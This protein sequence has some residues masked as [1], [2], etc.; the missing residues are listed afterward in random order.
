MKK[1]FLKKI[2]KFVCVLTI[3]SLFLQFVPAR[4]PAQAS[5]VGDW[6]KKLTTKIALPDITVT[7][8]GALKVGSYPLINNLP[9]NCAQ[10]DGNGNCIKQVNPFSQ[11]TLSIDGKQVQSQIDLEEPDLVPGCLDKYIEASCDEKKSFDEKVVCIADTTSMLKGMPSEIPPDCINSKKG[12][13]TIPKTSLPEICELSIP[14]PGD[15]NCSGSGEKCE[16]KILAKNK[17]CIYLNRLQTSAA[18]E[19]YS[20]FKIFNATDPF[21]D[22]SFIRNCRTNCSL[23]I[24]E[25]AFSVS[26][27]DVAALFIPGG[28]LTVIQKILNI[29]KM[30][31]QAF[32]IYTAIKD[33]LSSGVTFLNDLF[34]VMGQ[35]SSMYASFTNL[36]L[37]WSDVL[38][39]GG[40]AVASI[41]GGNQLK[42]IG[43]SSGG[44]IGWLEG[45]AGSALTAGN[46]LLGGVAASAVLNTSRVEKAVNGMQDMLGNFAQ[47]NLKF[48]TAKSSAIQANEKLKSSV[49][50]IRT[51]FKNEDEFSFFFQIEAQ[52]DKK[53][54]LTSILND[55]Q[56][57]F[58][59]VDEFMSDISQTANLKDGSNLSDL[60]KGDWS[61]FCDPSNKDCP[62]EN[63]PYY[64]TTTLPTR[65]IELDFSG[66]VNTG[67]ESSPSFLCYLRNGVKIGESAKCTGTWLDNF[68]TATDGSQTWKDAFELLNPEYIA[69][70][71]VGCENPCLDES[72]PPTAA[73]KGQCDLICYKS[74]GKCDISYQNKNW[75]LYW[76]DL[77]RRVGTY[78][79]FLLARQYLISHGK[80][81]IA[82]TKILDLLLGGKGKCVN[83]CSNPN[84]VPDYR[85]LYEYEFPGGVDRKGTTVEGR[86]SDFLH[87]MV[88]LFPSLSYIRELDALY[89]ESTSW[90]GSEDSP[91]VRQKIEES[92]QSLRIGIQ[93][94]IGFFSLGLN[95]IKN[96][97]ENLNTCVD[98]L[99]TAPNPLEGAQYWENI[100][101]YSNTPTPINSSAWSQGYNADVAYENWDEKINIL[102]SNAEKIDDVKQALELGVS[103]EQPIV[104]YKIAQ[105]NDILEKIKATAQ[106][107]NDDNKEQWQALVDQ[108][109]N[110]IIYGNPKDGFNG[111]CSV[112]S[113]PIDNTQDIT[114]CLRDDRGNCRN[115]YAKE[116]N[117]VLRDRCEGG[118]FQTKIFGDNET[119]CKNYLNCCADQGNSPGANACCDIG[120]A[121][122][123]GLQTNKDLYFG[124]PDTGS[125]SYKEECD[126]C[127]N[128]SCE[129]CSSNLPGGAVCGNN[130][131]ETGEQCDDGNTESQDGCSFDCQYEKYKCN[132]A[133]CS[134]VGN[135]NGIYTDSKCE[136]KCVSAPPDSGNYKCRDI[137]NQLGTGANYW[138]KCVEYPTQES[139]FVCA[140]RMLSDVP[141]RK[142]C[143]STEQNCINNVGTPDITP[144]KYKCSGSPDYVCSENSSG[145]YTSLATCRNSCQKPNPNLG[146]TLCRY[147]FD[148]SPLAPWCNCQESPR[149]T[150]A[151]CA[152]LRGCYPL[153]STCND[154]ELAGTTPPPP[155][156]NTKHYRC[157]GANCLR[158]DE[159]GAYTTSNC[160][161]RCNATSPTYSCRLVDVNGPKP[162]CMCQTGPTYESNM[163]CINR[164]DCYVDSHC[165]VSGKSASPFAKNILNNLQQRLESFAKSLIAIPKVF[166]QTA[167]QYCYSGCVINTCPNTLS[168]CNASFD[169]FCRT[170]NRYCALEQNIYDKYKCFEHYEPIYSNG[171]V[172][173]NEGKTQIENLEAQRGS[174]KNAIITIDENLQSVIK[175]ISDSFQGLQSD[176][177]APMEW[178]SSEHQESA[179]ASTTINKI[180]KLKI[181]SQDII[182]KQIP[183]AQSA[184]ATINDNIT[185][186]NQLIVAVGDNDQTRTLKNIVD[187]FNRAI[188]ILKN[189]SI[190]MNGDGVVNLDD[191]GVIDF[192][193]AKIGPQGLG[194][195][196]R[197][198]VG[199]CSGSPGN[200]TFLCKLACFEESNGRTFDQLTVYPDILFDIENAAFG[201][202]QAGENIKAIEPSMDMNPVTIKPNL[203][204]EVDEKVQCCRAGCPQ[205]NNNSCSFYRSPLDKD[206]NAT[207]DKDGKVITETISCSSWTLAS[208]KCDQKTSLYVGQ[209][210][211]TSNYEYFKTN[212]LANP[213][214]TL[215]E[216]FNAVSASVNNY[217]MLAMQHAFTDI[218]KTDT[219]PKID[220]LIK[221]NKVDVDEKKYT[222]L[223]SNVL[224]QARYLWWDLI[225]GNDTVSQKLL[226][227]CNITEQIL[228][229]N[230]ADI[231][232]QC[233][234]RLTQKEGDVFVNLS[235]LPPKALP[236]NAQGTGNTEEGYNT[237]K[238]QCNILTS[239]DLDVLE[240]LKDNSKYI[241]D[242]ID[243]LN[244]LRGDVGPDHIKC[245]KWFCLNPDSGTRGAGM[246]KVDPFCVKVTNKYCQSALDASEGVILCDK[247]SNAPNSYED[248][249]RDIT[250]NIVWDPIANPTDGSKQWPPVGANNWQGAQDMCISTQQEIANLNAL[251]EVL[252]S[253]G[254]IDD[255]GAVIYDNLDGLAKQC[256]NL[257]YQIDFARDCY[258]FSILQKAFGG[259]V[260]IDENWKDWNLN[261]F[262]TKP[263]VWKDGKLQPGTGEITSQ[264]ED[265]ANVKK[266]V[267][268]FCQSND[269]TQGKIITATIDPKNSNKS[270]GDFFGC[271]SIPLIFG[272]DLGVDLTANTADAQQAREVALKLCS[273][274]TTDMR[275]PLNE[276]MK[277][278]SVL[279]GVKSYTAASNGLSALYFDAQKVRQRAEDVVNLIKEAPKKFAELWN[280]TDEIQKITKD[281]VKI[282]Y[283][284]CIASPM[285][286]YAG[287]SQPLTGENGGPVC[288]NVN[289][290]FNQLDASFAMV[291]QN[292][293]AIDMTRRQPTKAIGLGKLS[294]EIPGEDIYPMDPDLNDIVGP[295][296]EKA[297]DIKNK[298]QLLWALATA[299]N[300]ANENCSCGQSYC[301][302]LGPVPLCISGL[303]LTLA[304]LK[305][306]FCHLVWTLRYPLGSLAEKLK[307]E[308]EQQ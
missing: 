269:A 2:N 216:R 221:D 208:K 91:G 49:E 44:N 300:Y 295:I 175:D 30:I 245:P 162:Y 160:D 86:H 137:S 201:L 301:P 140:N 276:I 60:Q 189:N 10:K 266:A 121:C 260:A 258:N 108:I 115:C 6:L 179:T 150:D 181:N 5:L 306:P 139:S 251:K 34:N 267:S 95:Q 308:L 152:F 191:Y 151:Q 17:A 167:K 131:T 199:K 218:P 198:G 194:N 288:P 7:E 274:S 114:T 112:E 138:C 81:A 214:S 1:N 283:V 248:G 8:K 98:N 27:L 56:L 227:A 305:E 242:R 146:S 88:D 200:S 278:L 172:E 89:S 18:Q 157:S 58:R 36:G 193:Y 249:Q 231:Q 235:L 62:I 53:K 209:Q 282:Q 48:A 156:S 190:D 307:Q 130:K 116:N 123:K 76:E 176:W 19:V 35:L 119:S 182:G 265:I 68:I 184:I 148:I 210:T 240:N 106:T 92:L 37:K 279:L 185:A 104:V 102:K 154:N 205:E 32:K 188:N 82:V 217:L 285:I 142:D 99:H 132:G 275:T 143:Y 51:S 12:E 46:G 39:Y 207:L 165:S 304:P 215:E 105:A 271:S 195:L 264:D 22:C 59:S 257:N 101:F 222:D 29:A 4:Q 230:P 33:A 145:V 286:S 203:V 43:V 238:N 296:Y 117:M 164:G 243:Q 144:P 15:N 74:S 83:V 212:L 293:R 272:N 73:E 253:I 183:D 135:G 16:S 211:G 254:A 174:L 133:V 14:L 77:G 57:F 197:C 120:V 294:V 224:T 109:I 107:L 263:P 96:N 26:L 64:C 180:L 220:A 31:N 234:N 136:N 192:A 237:L 113:C 87:Y 42:E 159:N 94:D 111:T 149:D 9:N 45:K 161:N 177:N 168:E 166:A 170:S 79:N 28:W 78:K 40:G 259:K 52:S 241:K 187:G 252:T 97:I 196:Y 261:E 163:N 75:R 155:G 20:A 289:E 273:Q 287:N 125:P 69:K 103:P 277:V 63:Y 66:Y 297:N 178:F 90:G 268:G 61:D 299:I 23:R 291:R 72:C 250:P 233:E 262:T 236:P 54:Q 280:S 129:D 228:T 284:K 126:D 55:F 247:G 67:D 3:L 122:D 84:I 171:C 213:L 11:F 153:E 186:L 50:N 25:V 70:K 225:W 65:N 204:D 298:T 239:V 124:N 302:Q 158:D 281:N 303:P 255:L 147:L 13:L 128:Q 141:Q 127:L 232:S 110:S 47:N 85:N 290:Q 223:A 134:N 246:N 21:T 38:I 270:I 202:I 229:N 244:K 256:N 41:Y 219:T 24:G 93:R 80:D 169:N 118:I 226:P 292:L 206:G 71:I 173:Y 100:L